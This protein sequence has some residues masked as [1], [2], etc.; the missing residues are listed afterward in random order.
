MDGPEFPL[1]S[2][3]RL[4]TEVGYSLTENFKSWMQSDAT[5]ADPPDA[6]TKT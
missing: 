4:K 1:E 2:P 5:T 6:P 3:A